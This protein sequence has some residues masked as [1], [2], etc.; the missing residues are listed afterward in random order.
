MNISGVTD[1]PEM[2]SYSKWFLMYTFLDIL[3]LNKNFWP[4][5]GEINQN[6][7]STLFWDNLYNHNGSKVH[8]SWSLI[9]HVPGVNLISHQEWSDILNSC[10]YSIINW[11]IIGDYQKHLKKYAIFGLWYEQNKFGPVDLF[12]KTLYIQMHCTYIYTVF[13]TVLCL[14][15]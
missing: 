9:N 12:V 14:K 10:P 8:I 11:I 15:L 2:V 1:P 13:K 4:L 7:S 5:F 3:F 6:L